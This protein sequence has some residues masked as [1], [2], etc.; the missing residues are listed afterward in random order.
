[1]HST[2]PNSCFIDAFL[3]THCHHQEIQMLD[4]LL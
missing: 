2:A 1:L 4:K 3:S